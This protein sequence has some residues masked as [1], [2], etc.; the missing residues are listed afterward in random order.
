MAIAVA[1]CLWFAEAPTANMSPEM[2]VPSRLMH[3]LEPIEGLSFQSWLVAMSRYLSPDSKPRFSFS[4][5]GVKLVDVVDWSPVGPLDQ[6]WDIFTASMY[7]P[8]V[9]AFPPGSVLRSSVY[10]YLSDPGESMA[11]AVARWRWLGDAPTENMSPDIRPAPLRLM[12]MLEPI[13]G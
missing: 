2:R 4:A 12:H 3:M 1:R 10:A 6:L 11:I 5:V 8:L 9:H 13:E 7:L